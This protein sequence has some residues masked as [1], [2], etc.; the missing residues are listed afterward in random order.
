MMNDSKQHITALIRFDSPYYVFSIYKLLLGLATIQYVVPK[1]LRVFSTTC[2]PES[3][4]SFSM[5]LMSTNR[6]ADDMITMYMSHSLREGYLLY[7]QANFFAC[8][9]ALRSNSVDMNAHFPF[10]FPIEFVVSVRM[11]MCEQ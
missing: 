9:G 7:Q 1:C 8:A 11:S 10:P 3:L 6:S 4:T 5:S 2:K